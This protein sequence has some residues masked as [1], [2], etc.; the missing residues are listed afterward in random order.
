MK[1]PHIFLPYIKNYVCNKYFFI[2]VPVILL[3]VF[4]TFLLYILKYNTLNAWGDFQNLRIPELIDTRSVHQPIIISADKHEHEFV[5]WIKSNTQWYNGSYL[6]PTVKMYRWETTHIR[7]VNNLDEDTNVHGHGL[8]VSWE[9]DGWEQLLIPV[10]KSWDVH[11]P[12]AQEASTNWYHPHLMHTTSKQVHSGLAGFYLIEDE[13]SQSLG[14]PNT[15]GINDIP[16][17]VQDRDFK[18][19]K[20]LP[21]PQRQRDTTGYQSTFVVNGTLNPQLNVPAWMIRLRLLNGANARPYEFY[22]SGKKKFYKIATEGWLLEK[23]V[24]VDKIRMAPWERNE[25]IIDLSDGNGVDVMWKFLLPNYNNFTALF[26]P[27][28]RVIRINIDKN[29]EIIESI[30]PQKLNDIDWYDPSQ[31]ENVRD[32]KLSNMR[33]NN[34]KNGYDAC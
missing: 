1:I 28:G 19:G 26:S 9:I 27:R 10:W 5:P 18:N 21:Y 32:F 3:F 23:P 4:S 29:L 34:K 6:W 17:V 16:L 15:Y 12:V 8:H 13:N 2:W 20:M 7:F 22:L 25:I 33:I 24:E 14:L 31:V 11:I 30:L